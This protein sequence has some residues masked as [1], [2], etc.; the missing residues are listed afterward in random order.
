[1]LVDIYKSRATV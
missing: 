1:M